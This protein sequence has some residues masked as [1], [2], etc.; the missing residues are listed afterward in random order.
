M[1]AFEVIFNDEPNQ[2][3]FFFGYSWADAQR[4]APILQERP[5]ICVDSDYI[6]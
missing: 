1:W 2:P 6:D 4:R 5:C 3:Y